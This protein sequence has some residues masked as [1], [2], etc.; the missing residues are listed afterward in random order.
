MNTGGGAGGGGGDGPY[1]EGG[2]S[3]SLI[4]VTS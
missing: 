4:P 2:T 3:M 1:A